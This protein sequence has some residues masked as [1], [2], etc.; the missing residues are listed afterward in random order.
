M[1]KIFLKSMT[2]L[3]AVAM[4]SSCWDTMDDKAD[5]D[6]AFSDASQADKV[7]VVLVD[8]AVT[9]Y[10]SITASATVADGT[11]L[12][13]Q[14]ILIADN[15]EFVDALAFDGSYSL[16][17]EF[18]SEEDSPADL[19][20]YEFKD[21]VY[22]L[23]ADEEIDPEKEYFAKSMPASFTVDAEGLEGDTEYYVCAYAVTR[24]AGMVRSNVMQMTTPPIPVYETPG[25]YYTIT[26]YALDDDNVVDPSTKAVFWMYIMEDP[27]D[28]T[29]LTIV[30]FGGWY[31]FGNAMV[32]AIYDPEEHMIYIPSGSK[33]GEYPGY[34]SMLTGGINESITAY[35]KNIEIEFEPLGGF[36]T[37]IGYYRVYVNAGT[38]GW[39]TMSGVHDVEDA[40]EVKPFKSI[41]EIRALK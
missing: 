1:K 2:I 22:Q 20:L 9:S 8:A 36:L 15:P 40:E 5:I 18:E 30:N 14:G 11:D 16:F 33:I 27:D 26:E 13:E 37:L 4:L 35:T 6:A 12:V 28:D 41:Q 38:I 24:K 29:A 32:E 7:G 25:G 31:N 34:G 21:G 19:G 17:E 39:Y 3:A 10:Q 23:T